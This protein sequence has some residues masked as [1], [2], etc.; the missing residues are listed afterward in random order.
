[1]TTLLT[2]PE[3]AV[4]AGPL[5]PFVG[6]PPGDSVSASVEMTRVSWPN[7]LSVPVQIDGTND[8]GNTWYNIGATEITDSYVVGPKSPLAASLFKFSVRWPEFSGAP[9]V[10]DKVR[11]VANSNKAFTTAI[12]VSVF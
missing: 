10:P 5:G 7:N 1:M 3:T 12:T 11:V 4:P 6:Q 2:I 8:G 9:R